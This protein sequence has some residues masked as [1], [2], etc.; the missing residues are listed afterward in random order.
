MIFNFGS[1]FS[2]L[3]LFFPKLCFFTNSFLLLLL[4]FG[5][6]ELLVKKLSNPVIFSLSIFGSVFEFK[7]KF[8][9]L[10]LSTFLFEDILI[11]FN[12]EE[13]FVWH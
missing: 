9:I 2:K 3:F 6:L 8:L 5:F 12:L 13:V 7:L 4:Y 11:S 10:L 1:F